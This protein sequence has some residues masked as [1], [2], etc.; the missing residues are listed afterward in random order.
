MSLS[1]ILKTTTSKSKGPDDNSVRFVG[2][3]GTQE[4][5]LDFS[6]EVL[7]SATISWGME[8]STERQRKSAPGQSPRRARKSNGR[9][10]WGSSSQASLPL[11]LWRDHSGFCLTQ[12]KSCESLCMDGMWIWARSPW[13]HDGGVFL[14]GRNVAKFLGIDYFE[15]MSLEW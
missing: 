13:N 2:H 8:W 9:W 15:V 12:T 14:H 5:I 10:L 11:L 4:H 1:Y 3:P 6:W 7:E